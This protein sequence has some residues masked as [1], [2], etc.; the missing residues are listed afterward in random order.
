MH[1]CKCAIFTQ[2]H[3][4]AIFLRKNK[5]AYPVIPPFILLAINL[6]CDIVHKLKKVA[7]F[8]GPVSC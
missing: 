7:G 1:K 4:T 2:T 6:T 5:G 3:G 8:G